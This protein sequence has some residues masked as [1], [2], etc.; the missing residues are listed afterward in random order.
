MSCILSRLIHRAS[1]DHQQIFKDVETF[2][3]LGNLSVLPRELR[4]EIYAHVFPIT[5]YLRTYL[6]R[7]RQYW[8][9]IDPGYPRYNLA[10]FRLS[11]TIY[12]EAMTIFY[13]RTTFG[14]SIPYHRISDFPS[15]VKDRI[16]NVFGLCVPFQRMGDYTNI[17]TTTR[18]MKAKFSSTNIIMNR[19]MNVNFSYRMNTNQIR[20]LEATTALPGPIAL[21]KGN[22]VQRNSA[23]I[24]FKMLEWSSDTPI[25]ICSPLFEALK[26]LTGFRTVTL[27]L[28]APTWWSSGRLWAELCAGLEP[29]MNEITLA[30]EPTLGNSA[31]SELGPGE[32]RFMDS[33]PFRQLVF[34][35]RDHLANISRG[36]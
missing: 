26:L 9:F 20:N 2:H 13:S 19:M 31:M 18:I 12:E 16:M 15:T 7:G 22:S 27:R 32:D 8:I 21:F 36:Q 25:Q 10:I 5:I 23:L 24:R 30:L 6:H 17:T 1:T 28:E 35:P 11:K 29:L 33:P 3:P 14:F 4:D 34:H